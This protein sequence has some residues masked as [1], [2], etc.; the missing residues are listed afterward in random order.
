[1]QSINFERLLNGYSSDPV[2]RGGSR[3][4][5]THEHEPEDDD[6][7]DMADTGGCSSRWVD[8]F[9]HFMIRYDACVYISHEPED[10]A[11]EAAAQGGSR[12]LYIPL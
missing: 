3:T 10:D 12:Y 8:V 1:M 4:S 2:G 11:G 7:G 9:T 5:S 6:A